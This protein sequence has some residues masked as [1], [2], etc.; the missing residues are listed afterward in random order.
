MTC[1]QHLKPCENNCT[2]KGTSLAEEDNPV[3]SNKLLE[4]F[5]LKHLQ[6]PTMPFLTNDIYSIFGAP[7]P[8]E[9][10]V[11]GFFMLRKPQLYPI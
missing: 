2:P 7:G 11:L 6:N 8:I 1:S 3:V 10:N 4:Y 9:Y 5:T